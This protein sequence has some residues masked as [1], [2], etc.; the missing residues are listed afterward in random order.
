MPSTAYETDMSMEQFN[1]R[2]ADEL[3][4]CTQTPED[5]IKAQ[6]IRCTYDP[7]EPGSALEQTTN[8]TR[9]ACPLFSHRP[10]TEIAK[11]HNRKPGRHTINDKDEKCIIRYHAA[12]NVQI[13]K[14]TP[15]AAIIGHCIECSYDPGAS[16]GSWR[17]QINACEDK[18]CSFWSVRR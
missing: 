3:S 5:R 8:C 15:A 16:N 12:I 11:G 10:R 14:G 7:R 18:D 1:Q 9:T 17:N 6:C 13:D 2:I 4:R